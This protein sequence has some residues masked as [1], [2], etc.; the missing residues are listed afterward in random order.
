MPSQHNTQ[1]CH[2]RQH[3]AKWGK[4]IVGM[5]FPRGKFTSV[6]S[7]VVKTMYSRWHH[8]LEMA[9]LTFAYPN[10]MGA[11]PLVIDR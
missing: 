9:Y 5:E 1:L 6:A 2:S 11:Y 3:L 8:D 4:K 7:T 10:N